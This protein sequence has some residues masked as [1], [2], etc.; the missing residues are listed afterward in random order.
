MINISIKSVKEKKD[1]NGNIFVIEESEAGIFETI[2][3]YLPSYKIFKEN[4]QTPRIAYLD[5]DR[6]IITAIL[7]KNVRD[8]LELGAKLYNVTQKFK[9]KN[10]VFLST[11][12]QLDNIIHG[13]CY[14]AYTFHLSFNQTFKNLN[15]ITIFSDNLDLSSLNDFVYWN[16]YYRWLV[17][18]PSNICTPRFLVNEFLK[19]AKKFGLKAS[20]LDKNKIKKMNLNGHI[21]VSG[22]QD[23]YILKVSNS[24]SRI[25]D[26]ALLGK[27]I[28]FDTGGIC[29]KQPPGMYAM[30][31][32][33]AGAALAFSLLGLIKALNIPTKL[34]AFIGITKNSISENSYNPGDIIKMSNGTLVQVENTD[35]E[36]RLLLADLVNLATSQGYKNIITLATLTGGVRVGLGLYHA[37]FFCTDSDL[38]KKIHL[39]SE[40]AGEPTCELPLEEK[41]ADELKI[42]D[43]LINNIGTSGS[44][45]PI[46]GA[47]FIKHFIPKDC[48]FTH[49]D[50]AGVCFHPSKYLEH[51]GKG[52]TGYGLRLFY[53]L[54]KLR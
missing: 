28:T 15:G 21:A 25:S 10:F 22:D 12:K 43:G 47:M 19:Q 24:D 6:L 20:L 16:Y 11:Y 48:S 17:D 31:A 51:W 49:F 32:D 34:S 14:G 36:G 26:F 13:F 40:K 30:K 35:A 54:F 52:A 29:L 3:K 39:A 8:Q 9:F 46:I 4:D 42:S 5:S 50:L 44:G 1:L 38:A 53:E 2:K 23:A 7:P 45:Q 27:G 18:L 37:G 41:Y 33:M